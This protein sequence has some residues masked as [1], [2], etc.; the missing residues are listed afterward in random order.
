[1][2]FSGDPIGTIQPLLALIN[3]VSGDITEAEK[4]I[5]IRKNNLGVSGSDDDDEN[6]YREELS[7]IE[8]DFELLGALR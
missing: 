3:Q 2:A 8:S 6:H 7:V 5:I 1:M 4:Q